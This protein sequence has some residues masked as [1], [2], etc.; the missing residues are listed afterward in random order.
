MTLTNMQPPLDVLLQQLHAIVESIPLLESQGYKPPIIDGD[1]RGRNGDPILGLR[2][3]K[4]AVNREVEIL[5]QVKQHFKIYL[6]LDPYDS[7]SLEQ[8]FSC[9]V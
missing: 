9:L 5:E 1:G 4:D 7:R 3:F 2:I 6:T 8:T